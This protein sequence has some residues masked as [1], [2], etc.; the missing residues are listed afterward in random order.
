MASRPRN[1]STTAGRVDAL[2]AMIEATTAVFHGLRALAV[3]VHGPEAACMSPG[4]AS[5][6]GVLYELLELGPRSVPEMARQRLVSRQHVQVVVNVLLENGLAAS[7]DNPSHRRS[8]LVGLTPRGSRVAK[9]MKRRETRLWE[10]MRV[11]A[12]EREIRKAVTV[13]NALRL[14]LSLRT[15]QAAP[16]LGRPRHAA[17]ARA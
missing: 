17:S 15:R 7:I 6:R 8:S 10:R 2:L 13:L 3:E 9:A 14:T 11:P 12:T 4:Q 16:G 1:W 5:G